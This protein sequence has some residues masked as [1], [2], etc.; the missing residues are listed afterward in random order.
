MT[1]PGKR[2]GGTKQEV[3]KELSGL[4][5]S[6][7]ARVGKDIYRR[8]LAAEQSAMA[9]IDKVP[10]TDE[11]WADFRQSVY[12]P[13]PA[14]VIDVQDEVVVDKEISEA[15]KIRNEKAKQEAETRLEKLE[16]DRARVKQEQLEEATQ[17]REKKD[18]IISET[19]E[20]ISEDMEAFRDKTKDLREDTLDIAERATKAAGSIDFQAKFDRLQGI[21]ETLRG[22]Y[23]AQNEELDDLDRTGMLLS[24]RRGRKQ[25][26][27]NNYESKITTAQAETSMIRGNVNFAFDVIDRGANSI[28][29]MLTI[30]KSK[31]ESIKRMGIDEMNLK[32]ETVGRSTEEKVLVNDLIK[33]INNDIANVE[34]NR[35][36]VKS[37]MNNNPKIVNEADIKLTDNEEEIFNKVKQYYADNP[38]EQATES[39]WSLEEVED[40]KWLKINENTGDT[41]VVYDKSDSSDP[42]TNE[43]T[44][45]SK[46]FIGK[47]GGIYDFT[48]YAEDTEWGYTIK[49]D[50]LSIISSMTTSEQI[51][52]Y[53]KGTSLAGMGK[54]ILDIAREYGIDPKIF[55]AVMAHETGKFASD[56]LKENNNPGGITWQPSFGEDMRGSP[57]PG[58]E[59]GFYARFDT[60]KQG[61]RNVAFEIERR[62]RKPDVSDTGDV[63][64]DGDGDGDEI[65]SVYAIDVFER[66]YG[67]VPPFGFTR[68]D[69]IEYM[70]DNPGLSPAELQAAAEEEFKKQQGAEA[71]EPEAQVEE[72]GWVEDIT[73]EDIRA[74]FTE[75]EL[76][77]ISD[78]LGIAVWWK[79]KSFDIANAMPTIISRV[80][81]VTDMG[82]SI[83]EIK[84]ILLSKNKKNL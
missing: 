63:D 22:Y 80:Q 30:E 36:T 23:D 21:E 73:E 3:E 39:N 70:R 42:V 15:Q 74:E 76:Y 11:E 17:E 44:N 1:Q 12:A 45:P 41:E 9:K 20:G 16:R 31:Y 52:E 72:E 6:D 40:G 54:E 7:I 48:S 58:S 82:G 47:D 53:L 75:E 50:Y 69:L 38:I 77:T 18:K 24:V 66:K 55:M 34:A 67:W 32:L 25:K 14:P 71:G 35:Y 8:N 59:G 57:R 49:S 26:V 10:Q 60:F 78:N 2:I 56:V 27:I 84:R 83:E 81:K 5:E 28:S 65:M 61:L 79:H 37:L 13:T 19:Q 51:N 64:D 29:N 46:V 33:D 68:N 62:K 43:P 4:Q